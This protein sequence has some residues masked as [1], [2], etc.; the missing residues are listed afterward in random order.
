MDDSGLEISFKEYRLYWQEGTTVNVKDAAQYIIEDLAT[1]QHRIEEGIKDQTQYTFAVVVANS[2]GN[3]SPVGEKSQIEYTAIDQSTAPET[4]VLNEPASNV[5]ANEVKI[6]L[7]WESPNA[8]KDASGAVAH[9]VR[10]FLYW[11]AG[12]TVSEEAFDEIV[13]LKGTENNYEIGGL[14][15]GT[16]YAML[17][18]VESN[19]EKKARSNII[20][21]KTAE[22]NKS[23]PQQQQVI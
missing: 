17:L 21:I 1:T 22:M 5:T 12:T 3:V 8:G 14:L 9:V 20:T 11:K 23:T 7:T 18:I 15:F 13:E 6:T 10:Y 19:A 4:L 16:D 2:S